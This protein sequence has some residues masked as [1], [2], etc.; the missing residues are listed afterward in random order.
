MIVHCARHPF[1]IAPYLVL[2]LAWSPAHAGDLTVDW[3]LDPENTRALAVPRF[4]WLEDETLLLV[5]AAKPEAERSLERLDPRSL[6]R[7]PAGDRGKILDGWRALVGDEK[8]P[9]SVSLPLAAS[10]DSKTL[11]Y[12]H[13]GDIFLLDLE[14]SAVR[15]I[16]NTEAQEAAP[17]FS[18][19][20][21]W[22]A[23]VRE[24]DIHAAETASGRER[25]LTRDGS[26]TR[27]NGKLSWVYWE[28]I[29][30]RRDEGYRWSPDSAAILY[31]QSDDS[32]VS[33]Y[34]LPDHEPATPRVRWQ[35]YPK[36]GSQNPVVRAGVVELG[37][38]ETRW[39]DLEKAEKDR[40]SIEYIARCAW[41][42]DSKRAVLQTLNRAQNHLRVWIVDRS[43]GDVR[44][45]LEETSPTYINLHR[46]LHFLPDGERFL[47]VSE[48]GGFRHLYLHAAKGGPAVNLTSGEWALRSS[49]GAGPYLGSVA[50]IDASG[51]QVLLHAA[52]PSPLETQI[53]RVPLDGKAMVR[54][55]EG[56]GTHSATVSPGG[57]FFVDEYSRSGVPPRLTLHRIDGSLLHVI[58]PSGTDKLAPFSLA[59]PELFTVSAGDGAQ[60]P[61]RLF[62]PQL[63]EEGRKYPA[64]VYVYGGPGAP[65]VADKW[66]G[67]WYL[68]SQ[69]LAKR[70]FA[71]FTVDPRSASDQGKA[72]EDA[73]HRKFYGDVE[74]KD[75][76][77]GVRHLKS[78]S[79]VDP[80]R[81]GI[82]GWSGGGTNTVYAM[83]RSEEFR[84]GI[85]VAGVADQRYYDTI[86]TER[87][88]GRPAENEE[89]YRETAA[90]GAAA[91]L[92]GRLL[93]VHGTADDN[94]HP[95]NAMRL[96]HE[97][98]AAGKQFDLMLYPRR[99]H[100]IGDP[101]ARKHLFQLML[102]FWERNLRG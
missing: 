34:P 61:A 53:F 101:V 70:G 35:R 21:R 75:I 64:I 71:V 96:V 72:K 55:S 31:L 18:P 97:L 39:I 8:A 58:H 37:G 16:T 56:G 57:R 9:R 3:L 67:T 5:D 2:F 78:L 22:V 88:L 89:G 85:A 20:G 19:D 82:W 47:W 13:S 60:L 84:A 83:T 7:K 87:Y 54:L 51:G 30:D 86:Y 73:V 41:L 68:W 62:R 79:F 91:K 23:Y 43:G 14:A 80:A 24:N 12:E 25:R 38:G 45:A 52:S 32:P 29:M 44:L 15:R 49:G 100:G 33:Q 36:A 11:L 40:A 77:A 102:E 98:I 81:V 99:D 93:V 76:L 50:W 6:E 65:A 46:D 17:R 42:P 1:R 74:L 63:I 95:Q 59:P 48:R 26:E 10:L 69:V 94:V 28:E 90:A 4:L 92:H 27:L 66:D